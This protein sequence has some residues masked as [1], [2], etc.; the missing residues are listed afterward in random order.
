MDS[1][2]E[3]FDLP[4]SPSALPFSVVRSDG[5]FIYLGYVGR[6]RCLLIDD[7][8]LHNLLLIY[9]C[10]PKECLVEGNKTDL[11]IKQWLQGGRDVQNTSQ[12]LLNT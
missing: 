11:K 10:P 3:C 4:A 12:P 5:G 1:V 7:I 9:I 8:R 2:P 6:D